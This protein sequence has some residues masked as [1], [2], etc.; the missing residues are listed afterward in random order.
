MGELREVL[1]GWHVECKTGEVVGEETERR[2]GAT[3]QG[4]LSYLGELG[5]RQRAL[6]KAFSFSVADGLEG[7]RGQLGDCCNDPR[8]DWGEWTGKGATIVT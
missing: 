7:E 8:R 5:L 6:A 3:T 2:A 4:F 1:S